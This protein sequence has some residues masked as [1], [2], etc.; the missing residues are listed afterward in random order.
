MSRP[1]DLLHCRQTL[2]VEVNFTS[3]R[4]F[5]GVDLR[6]GEVARRAGIRPSTIRYY[7]KIGLLPPPL[8]ANG[9]R[10]YDKTILERVAIVRFAKRVGFS[11]AEIM[12]LLS[13]PPGRPPAERWRKI[14]HQK[15]T[16]VDELI[17]EASSVR[18]MLLATLDQKCPKLVERGRSLD[19]GSDLPL[20]ALNQRHRNPSERI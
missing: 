8:R 17:A 20:A 4:F 11:I 2:Q 5:V 7:E 12:I 15:V 14:A 19:G 6:I 9:R 18:Q 3:R 1:L 10:L 16:Q 13:G